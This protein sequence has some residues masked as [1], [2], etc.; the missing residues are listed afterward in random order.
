MLRQTAENLH[1]RY[2][3]LDVST[4]FST[5]TPAGLLTNQSRSAAMVIVGAHERGGFAGLLAGP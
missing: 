1:R 4:L 5:S 3:N 2:P